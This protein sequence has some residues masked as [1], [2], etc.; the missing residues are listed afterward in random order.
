MR[1]NEECA[2]HPVQCRN[3]DTRPPHGEHDGTVVDIQLVMDNQ[4]GANPGALS[5]QLRP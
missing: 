4:Q 2:E 5:L 3:K 1:H